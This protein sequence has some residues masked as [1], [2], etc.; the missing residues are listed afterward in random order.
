MGGAST[1]RHKYHSA[2]T[3][4]GSKTNAGAPVNI[5]NLAAFEPT[6]GGVYAHSLHEKA[7]K[8][9]SELAAARQM[10]A[11]DCTDGGKRVRKTVSRVLP[12]CWFNMCTIKFFHAP[13]SVT[14]FPDLTTEHAL[15]RAM[16]VMGDKD[17]GPLIL[18]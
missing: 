3:P 15:L 14:R 1:F 6:T 9:C 8:L 17:T 5:Q 10:C 16:L 4:A 2:S 18:K 13:L 7:R 11:Y 12:F